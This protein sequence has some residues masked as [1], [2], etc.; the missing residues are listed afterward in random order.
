MVRRVATGF[1]WQRC[2]SS[3]ISGRTRRIVVAVIERV[4]VLALPGVAPFELGVLCE[5]F[6]LDRSDDDIPG[7]EFTVCTVDG[8]P[9]RTSVG[10]HVQPEADLAPL[11]EADLIGVPARPKDR[12]VPGAA[13]AALQAADRRGAELLS[14]C[15]GAFVLGEAGLL[16]GRRCTTHWKYTA[17]LKQ[18]FPTAHVEPNSLYCEDANILTSAGTAAGIDLGLHIVRRD[19]GAEVA[20]RLARRMV[21]PPHRDGSQAQYTETPMPRT[22]SAPTLAPLLAWLMGHLAEPVTVETLAARQHMAVR[23]FARRFV[24]ETGVSPHEWITAQRVLLARRLLE[25]TDLGIDE[26]AER[27]GFGTAAVLRHHFGRRVGATPTA[28]RRRFSC[29]DDRLGPPDAVAG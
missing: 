26:V 1:E 25:Q 20:T 22:E 18:R 17:E 14:V 21:V 27:A 10:F 19:H 4:A 12:P 16:D 6:G 23:T 24:A 7:Y 29:R 2:H 13:L 15:S 3:S 28:Y 8:G 9:V 11:A 5:V